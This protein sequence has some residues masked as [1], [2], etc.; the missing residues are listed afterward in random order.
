M[1]ETT[2]E[3]ESSGSVSSL[4]T[5]G[6]DENASIESGMCSYTGTSSYICNYMH[7]YQIYFTW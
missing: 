5:E 3:D 4:P 2:D 1:L 6:K 7:M